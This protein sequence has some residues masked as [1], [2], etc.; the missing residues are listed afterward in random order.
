MRV[1]KRYLPPGWYPGTASQTRD[2]IEEMARAFPAGQPCGISGIVPHAGWE[3]SGSL[4]LE[5]LSRLSRDID[6]IVIIGGHLGPADGILCAFDDAYETPLGPI[7]ADLPL[8]EELRGVLAL[9]EDRYAD[10]TVEIQL[11]FLRH[12]F[13][14]ARALGMRAPPSHDAEK[15]GKAIDASARRLARR[16]VVV[17]ST[18]L[19]HYGA[20]YGFLPSGTGEKAVK[21]V[22]EIN[23][24]RFIESML[25]MNADSA[26]DRALHER[27]SCSA[28]GAVAAMSFARER[29]A[30]EGMLVRYMTSHEVHPAESFVGYAGILYSAGA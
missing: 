24:R 7:S 6:T 15:L 5:V 21:W 30:K 12:L 8:L 9:Q 22:R 11:P 27:S 2:A 25:S 18:D 4:A 10:N 1:R 14:N 26:L 28:G 17:G 3:Y 20:N 23:D 19:T 16:V 13:P 29:G